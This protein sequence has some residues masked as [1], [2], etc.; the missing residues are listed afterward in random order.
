M[1]I[2]LRAKTLFDPSKRIIFDI[3]KLLE[4]YK[5][6]R[7]TK[8]A[9]VRKTIYHR[10]NCWIGPGA[11]IGSNLMLPHPCGIVIGDKVTIGN[12]CTL[13]QQVTLGQNKGYYP[14]LGNGVIVYA[15][16]KIIGGISIG[17]NAV[18]GANAVVTKD[19]PENAIVG[20][21]PAKVIRM[22]DPVADGEMY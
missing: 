5:A 22:R 1:K 17:D 20:G 21:I 9:L 8:C 14:E 3:E 13:Y 12:N 16:A 18:I 19:V 15:G 11:K 4:A 7:M 2:M 10:Y 6:G